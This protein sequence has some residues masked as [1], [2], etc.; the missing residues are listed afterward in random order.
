MSTEDPGWGGYTPLPGEQTQPQPTRPGGSAGPGG[1]GRGG[2]RRVLIGG[3]LAALLVIAVVVIVV[4][5]LGSGSSPSPTTSSTAAPST[6]SPISPSGGTGALALGSGISI[7][8]AQG[9]TSERQDANSLRLTSPDGNETMFVTLG[10]AHT[11]DVTT[12]LQ[13]DIAT[14]RQ[15]PNYSSPK[16]SGSV[17]TTN[18]TGH[19]NRVASVLFTATD[20]AGNPVIGEY[21][22]ALNNQ[23]QNSVF[24]LVHGPNRSELQQNSSAVTSMLNT[25]G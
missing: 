19:F 3:G 5:T 16:L 23:S 4:V 25:L 8:P 11:A 20:S 24:A 9:W 22:E 7:T 1:A 21:V 12:A 18:I 13:S 2:G 15:N 6:P 10:P 17:Q 14:D